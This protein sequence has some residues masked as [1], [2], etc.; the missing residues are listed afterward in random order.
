MF[1]PPG[2]AYVYLVYGMH[3]CLNVVTEPAG[4]PAAVLVRAVEPIEG[5]G[6]MREARLCYEASRP[7]SPR[8]PGDGQPRASRATVATTHDRLA[9]LPDARLASGPG[10][11]G[12]AFSIEMAQSGLDLL[13]PDAPLRLE[14]A[15][16]GE[17]EPIIVGTRRVGIAYAGSP[18]AEAPWRLLVAGSPAISRPPDRG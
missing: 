10:L 13:D 15:R 3:R 16:P 14:P 18:W 17:P 4:Q 9:R 8:A 7:R 12:A 1:G 6:A 5:A 2:H 11:V